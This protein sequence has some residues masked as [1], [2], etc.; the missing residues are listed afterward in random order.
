[1]KQMNRPL[2][3]VSEDAMTPRTFENSAGERVEYPR[4]VFTAQDGSGTIDLLTMSE[5]IANGLRAFIESAV[6]AKRGI[7]DELWEI[8]EG[9]LA[10]FFAGAR[11]AEETARIIQNRAERWMSEQKLLLGG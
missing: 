10:D 7:G 6:G 5:E 2:A 4:E 1:M 3:S 9:D 11:S 8:I